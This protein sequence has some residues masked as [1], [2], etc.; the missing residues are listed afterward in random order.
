MM[1]TACAS[2]CC[3]LAEKSFS[4]VLSG[5]GPCIRLGMKGNRPTRRIQRP[6]GIVPASRGFQ[7]VP[8]MAA[9][10]L[11]AYS[12]SLHDRRPYLYREDY[13]P[14]PGLSLLP[15]SGIRRC[16]PVRRPAKWSIA[17][18]RGHCSIRNKGLRSFFPNEPWCLQPYHLRAAREPPRW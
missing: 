12:A 16:L 4:L 6:E 1:V 3:G 17:Q 11:P 2:T 14:K 9:R 8:V 10:R 18:L 7:E 15:G 5:A 13:D